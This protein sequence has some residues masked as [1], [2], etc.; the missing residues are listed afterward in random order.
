MKKELCARCGLSNHRWQWCRKEIS[1]S[2]T[3]KKGKKERKDKEPEKKE[4]TA[5]AS[6]VSL[7]RKAPAHTV[8][9]GIHQ[10]P[11]EERI[12]ANLRLKAAGS[13]KARMSGV[14]ADTPK[15]VW[16]DDS[17]DEENM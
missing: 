12:L 3:R 11:V 6:S 13:K 16:E 14:R 8:S 2:S 10:L 17:T 15:K 5:S 4:E 1:I 7:K 9:V